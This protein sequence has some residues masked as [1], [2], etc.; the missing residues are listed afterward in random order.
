L[1][2]ML[3]CALHPPIIASD[4]R[5]RFARAWREEFFEAPKWNF[6]AVALLDRL[7]NTVDEIHPRLLE[8]Y[9][10]EGDGL[11][12]A[13]TQSEMLRGV[14]FDWAPQTASEFVS[15]FISKMTSGT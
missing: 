1:L 5:V 14:I 12:G 11:S 4:H 9:A 3:R 8:A 6:E 2:W 10:W 15:E 13:E 7:T